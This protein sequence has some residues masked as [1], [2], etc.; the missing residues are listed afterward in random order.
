MLGRWTSPALVMRHVFALSAHTDAQ[1]GDQASDWSA[2][3]AASTAL[4]ACVRREVVPCFS[5][6]A[7][8]AVVR[9]NAHGSVLESTSV[10]AVPQA[11]EQ[12][13]VPFQGQHYRLG[14]KSLFP[15]S[16]RLHRVV[17]LKI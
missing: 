16:L 4:S 9:A 1:R 3:P 11:R 12:I 14:V 8:R 6:N 7:Q 15:L 17:P 13:E 2:E 10:C 5:T